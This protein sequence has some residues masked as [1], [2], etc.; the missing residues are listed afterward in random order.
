[1]GW[2]FI[3]EEDF[4]MNAVLAALKQFMKKNTTMPVPADIGNILSPPE[5][6]ITTAQYVAAQ[7]AWAA[8]GYG[9]FCD[10]LD[11]IKA[12]EKQQKEPR[13]GFENNL[14]DVVKSKQLEG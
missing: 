8:N 5:K 10:H 11:V 12:Y 14:L 1:M 6:E 3:L 4:P 13:L 7:K 9:S 2:K